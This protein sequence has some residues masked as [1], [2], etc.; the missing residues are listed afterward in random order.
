MLPRLS[1]STVTKLVDRFFITHPG[2]IQLVPCTDQHSGG[3][4][5]NVPG[6]SARTKHMGTTF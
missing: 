6:K 1:Y 5:N 4:Y 2:V 3:L